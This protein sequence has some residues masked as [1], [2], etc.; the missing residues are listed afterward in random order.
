MAYVLTI[1]FSKLNVYV[2]AVSV[3]L[4]VRPS[5]CDVMHRGRMQAYWMG[6]MLGG[7]GAGL[8]Y[9]LAF[10]ANASR[11]KLRAFFTRGDYDGEKFNK[12]GIEI[13]ID[14]GKRLIGD[15]DDDI[16]ALDSKK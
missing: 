8:V 6:P 16:E 3:C 11:A 9:D 1:I 10:A 2:R 12:N 14:T 5:V 7:I 13:E 4:S 15:I